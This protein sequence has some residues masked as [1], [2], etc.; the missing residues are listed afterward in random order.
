MGVKIVENPKNSSVYYV[1]INSKG[2]RKTVKIGQSKKLAK[3]VRDKIEARIILEG[4]DFLQSK[5]EQ[6]M[7]TFGEYVK[8]WIDNSGIYNFGWIDKIAKLS[9]KYSTY[10]GYASILNTHLLPVFGKM[11]INEITSRMIGDF[12]YSLLANGMYKTQTVKNVKNC[13]SAVLKYAVKP[14]G[15]ILTNP[16]KDVPVKKPKKEEEAKLENEED[17]D[18]SEPDPYTWEERRGVEMVFKEHYRRHYPMI[19]TGFRSGL[20]M[21]ELLALTWRCIDFEQ[22]LIYVTKNISRGRLTTPKTESSTRV[23]RMTSNLVHTLQEHKEYLQSIYDKLPKWVFP[24]NVGRRLNY[25]NFMD[26]VWNPAMKKIK[27]RR[28][29]PHD[30]RHTYC[31]LRLLSGHPISEVSREMGHSSPVTTFKIYFK[32]IPSASTTNIDE[33]DDDDVARK[34]KPD[35]NDSFD[36]K[37][38]DL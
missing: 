36:D 28:R 8:G 11:K 20:R 25:G 27:L 35:A 13:L 23:V 19:L 34:R 26:R 16:C 30:M 22:R 7:P 2:F 17:R 37:D 38:G 3:E 32:L 15:Y 12:V 18:D 6:K 33:L 5:N 1:R 10:T 24:N 29:T 14:D 21:G 9:N 31:T 4:L